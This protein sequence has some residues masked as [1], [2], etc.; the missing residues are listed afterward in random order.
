MRDFFEAFLNGSAHS[1]GWRVFL[2]K[3]R[4]FLLQ[5]F[6]LAHQTIEFGIG[7]R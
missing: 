3:P 6:E 7:Y 2:F 4:E 1:F 5:Q